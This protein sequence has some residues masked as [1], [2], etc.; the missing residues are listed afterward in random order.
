LQLA[1]QLFLHFFADMLHSALFLGW[2]VRIQY[3]ISEALV[4]QHA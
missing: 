2:V 4:W 3:V 1:L